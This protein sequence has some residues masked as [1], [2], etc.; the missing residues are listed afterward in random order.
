MVEK[1]NAPE[2]VKHGPVA[3]ALGIL[4]YPISAFTGFWVTRQSARSSVYDNA[5]FHDLTADLRNPLVEEA[6]AKGR[7]AAA[8]IKAGGK[9]D[10]YEMTKEMHQNFSKDI[11]TRMEGAT[12]GKLHKKWKF[13]MPHQKHKALIHGFTAAG[14]SIGALL[15]MANSKTVSNLFLNDKDKDQ[16]PSI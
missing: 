2:P 10:F 12:L 14:I 8:T 9:V 11:E 5:M 3:K 15:A 4:A 1:N 6:K 16:G 13:M 7:E